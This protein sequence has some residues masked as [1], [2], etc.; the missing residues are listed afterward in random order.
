MPYIIDKANNR[1]IAVNIKQELKY[2]LR[3]EKNDLKSV[4]THYDPKTGKN[5]VTPNK[6]PDNK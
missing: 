6:L 4:F 5:V 3:Y 2:T 1:I